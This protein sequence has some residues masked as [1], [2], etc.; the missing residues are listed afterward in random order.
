MSG[1]KGDH[2]GSH[3]TLGFKEKK[4]PRGQRLRGSKE[5][6]FPGLD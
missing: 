2:E 4:G 1:W 5:V 3:K 6:C